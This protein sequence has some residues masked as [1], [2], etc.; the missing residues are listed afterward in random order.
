MVVLNK[1]D[2]QA[3]ISI[4]AL[5]KRF[6]EQP[7]IILKNYGTNQQ[8]TFEFRLGYFNSHGVTYGSMLPSSDER[9]HPTGINY[10]RPLAGKIL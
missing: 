3:E 2:V 4:L 5:M 1:S 10:R 9:R 6:F 7:A 8:Y